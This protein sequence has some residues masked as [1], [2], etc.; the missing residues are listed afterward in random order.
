MTSGS[1]KNE[2]RKTLTNSLM[3]FTKTIGIWSAKFVFTDIAA[4]FNTFWT[5]FTFVVL[6]TIWVL[7]QVHFISIKINSIN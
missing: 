7:Q 3:N 6:T 5:Q 2:A 4:L 1:V